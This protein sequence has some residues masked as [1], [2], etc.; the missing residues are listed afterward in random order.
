MVTAGTYLKRHVLDAPAKRQIVTGALLEL[1]DRY[2]WSLQA[3]AVLPNH[4][5]FVAL[6]PDDPHNLPQLMRHLHST[7]ARELNRLDGCAGRRV[8][9]QYWDRLITYQRSY[10]ARLKYV[11]QNPLKHGVAQEP[12]AYRWCS[13]GWFQRTAPE[14]FRKTV[15]G[16][17]VDGVNV[18]DDF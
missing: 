18:A 7:T 2:G 17:K 8:W 13:A 10:L 16:L 5:H 11:L 3:W 14:A 9:Y 6:A 12:S 1:A 15:E 4:C